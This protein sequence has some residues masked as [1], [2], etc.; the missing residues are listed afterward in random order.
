MAEWVRR[1]T[2]DLKVWGSNPSGDN[3]FVVDNVFLNVD[4]TSTNFGLSQSTMNLMNV[5]AIT[6]SL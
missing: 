6:E 1:W 5:S 4:T 2:W 3:F